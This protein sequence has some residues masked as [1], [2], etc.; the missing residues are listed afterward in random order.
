MKH[1]YVLLPDVT[2]TKRVVDNL[3]LAHI[4]WQNIHVLASQDVSLEDLP[5][6]EVT[7]KS[8]LM[9]A[10]TRGTAVGGL[11]G[12]L[13]GLVAVVLPPVGLTLAGGAI[14]ATTLTGAGIGA[15]AGGLIGVSVPNSRLEQFEDA[16]KHGELLLM[17]DVAEER[18]EEIKSIIRSQYPQANFDSPAQKLSEAII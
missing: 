1:I 9:A 3:L 6:A 7:Q 2:L 4:N 18:E 16:I 8:D 11:S 5:Q 10:V 13:A 17:V 14:L 12:M 15:W